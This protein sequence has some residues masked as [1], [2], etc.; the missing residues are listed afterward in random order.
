MNKNIFYKNFVTFFILVG[1]LLLAGSTYYFYR[2]Y[3]AL[4]NNPQN[5]TQ[6]EIEALVAVVSKLIILPTEELPT[7]ATVKE[8]EKLKDKPFFAHARVGDKVLIYSQARKA[9]LYRPSEDKIIEVAPLNM[10]GE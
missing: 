4:E 1:A 7:A 2:E 3:H 8:P 9:I 6:K 10:G 5:R